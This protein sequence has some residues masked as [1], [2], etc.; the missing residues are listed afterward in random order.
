MIDCI[1]YPFCCYTSGHN[2]EQAVCASKRVRQWGMQH[3]A[4]LVWFLWHTHAHAHM[5][6]C[7][8]TGVWMSYSMRSISQS[9]KNELSTNRS[10]LTRVW[11]PA[12][13][14]CH[15]YHIWLVFLLIFAKQEFQEASIWNCGQLHLCFWGVHVHLTS[16]RTTGPS[17]MELQKI[18]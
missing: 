8:G 13:I 10:M 18:S 14:L 5:T 2:V 4:F 11:L 17:F 15:M 6:P 3:A 1:E 9:C 16:L 7:C 12:K